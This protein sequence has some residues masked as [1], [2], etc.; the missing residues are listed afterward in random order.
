VKL[1]LLHLG[2]QLHTSAVYLEDSP[3]AEEKD[4]HGEGKKACC[5]AA[6]GTSLSLMYM[7]AMHLIMSSDILLGV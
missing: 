6:E 3:L 2:L 1:S 4:E 7:A 5:A